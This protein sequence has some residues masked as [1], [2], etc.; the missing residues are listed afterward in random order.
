MRI[1]K[2]IFSSSVFAATLFLLL[3]GVS[4]AQTELTSFAI[5]VRQGVAALTIN[6]SARTQA[7]AINGE[8]YK[9]TWDEFGMNV[10]IN[11][12]ISPNEVD[13]VITKDITQAVQ[14]EK[15]YDQQEMQYLTASQT[16]PEEIQTFEG[17]NDSDLPPGEFIDPNPS[18]EINPDV[19]I[20]TSEDQGQNNLEETA[21]PESTSTPETIPVAPKTDTTTPATTVSSDETIFDAILQGEQTLI[22]QEPAPEST[23]SSSEPPPSETPPAE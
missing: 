20:S 14:A 3:S 13:R 2:K 7:Q 4:S 16:T 6:S 11:G 19:S 9:S 5:D 15:N 12:T 21:T 18:A 8:D 17:P 23:P 22:S 10:L 1:L